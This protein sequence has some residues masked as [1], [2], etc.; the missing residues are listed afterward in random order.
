FGEEKPVK[1]MHQY[2]RIDLPELK[3]RIVKK[4]GPE[5]SKQYLYFLR[6]FLSLKLSKVDFSELCLRILGKENIS[7]HNQFIRSILR[8]ACVAKSPPPPHAN[9]DGGVVAKEIPVDGYHHHHQQNRFRISVNQASCSTGLLNSGDMLPAS[10]R[11][12]RTGLRDRRNCDRR[13]A[14]G[15]GTKNSFAP[16]LSNAPP[17]AVKNGDLIS[18]NVGRRPMQQQRPG[19][20]NANENAIATSMSSGD[21]RH[22]PASVDSKES[23]ERDESKVASSRSPLQAPLGLP[24]CPANTVGGAHTIA[25]PPR[26]CRRSSGTFSDGAL[27]DSLALRERMKN[28]AVGQGLGG[29]SAECANLLNHGLDSYLKGLISSCLGIVGERSEDGTR[30]QKQQHHHHHHHHH[31]HP[32]L[33]LLNGVIKPQQ[34]S[35]VLRLISLQDLR[36]AMELRPPQLGQ[37]SPLLLERIRFEAFEE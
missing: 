17:P 12:A 32:H 20:E 4:L 15:P 11:R 6:K 30:S 1:I 7:L 3:A 8:N 21:D 29:V 5:A 22:R 28:I 24:S 33:K 37:D 14:L 23:L 35:K 27:V 25:P 34:E 18:H 13:S 36:V 26:S 10:P 2:S 9:D 31:P 19:D 16:Q